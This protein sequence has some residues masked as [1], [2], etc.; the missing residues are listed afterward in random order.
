[1]KIRNGNEDSFWKDAETASK[2]VVFGASQTA[3][4]FIDAL[5]DKSKV[6]VTDN[7]YPFL[8][9]FHGLAVCSPDRIRDLGEN[10]IVLVAS[11]AY[12][13][14]CR[15]IDKMGFKGS[16]YFLQSILIQ[17][18]MREKYAHA[19]DEYEFI[20]RRKGSENLLMVIAGFQEYYWK[21]L[22]ERVVENQKRFDE[23]IDICICVPQGKDNIDILRK[24]CEE[25]GWSF[26]RIKANQLAKAQNI[27]IYLHENARWI[28]KI[29]EDVVLCRDYF[30]RMKNGYK[31]AGKA[32]RREVGYLAPVMNINFCGS[33]V[34]LKTLELERE[35][36]YG[37]DNTFA[38]PA[39]AE[40][41]W[42]KST[43]F[44]KVAEIF[45][46]RNRD[47]FECCTT[48]FSVGAFLMQ[49][50]FW[51][52]MGGFTVAKEGE[53]GKEE[54]QMNECCI[55]SVRVM[56][57]DCSILAGHLGFGW[58]KERIREFFENHSEDFKICW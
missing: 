22:L 45:E 51:A 17:K 36:R 32:L 47:C 9:E 46:T 41:I 4:E 44:D 21:A 25:N 20:D 24:M 43:P 58:Q 35:F 5:R 14:I 8:S 55:N 19:K 33:E 26:L 37:N 31:K 1:M 30:S 29:D 54:A 12:V 39:V 50:D 3:G 10:D 2:I 16:V 23:S 34:F 28:Y 48:R 49:R 52:G 13:A 57:Q 11:R 15:Q 53:L 40:W 42:E 27:A 56:A 6:L 38:D 7:R 18:E